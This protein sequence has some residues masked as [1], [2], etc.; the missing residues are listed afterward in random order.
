MI[1]KVRYTYININILIY[2]NNLRFGRASV[3]AIS[4]RDY[5]RNKIDNQGHPGYD[6]M[7]NLLENVFVIV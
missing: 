6:D 3:N 2:K 5:R 7:D 4:T 1:Y